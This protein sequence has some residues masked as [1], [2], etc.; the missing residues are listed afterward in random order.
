MP[1]V[2]I[3][4][5]IMTDGVTLQILFDGQQSLTRSIQTLTDTTNN[6]YGIVSKL[7]IDV[8]ELR[9]YTEAGFD[10]MNDRF[11]RLEARVDGLEGQLAIRSR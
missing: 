5:G 11:D 10:T 3:I 2:P 4:V 8:T 6:I 7:Q 1:E 9:S